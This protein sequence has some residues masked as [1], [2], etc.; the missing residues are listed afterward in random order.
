VESTPYT[1]NDH[2]LR[3]SKE[4]YLAEYKAARPAK[5]LDE[6]YLKEAL[7][8]LRAA[9]S[10]IKSIKDFMKH[11]EDP[12]ERELRVAAE[13]RAY[14]Q[15]SYKAA[16]TPSDIISEFL[17]TASTSGSLT[18]SHASSIPTFCQDFTSDLEQL[19]NANSKLAPKTA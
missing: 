5:D 9:G 4:K 17:T 18:S 13:V 7:S 16:F 3:S 1:Q 15:V 14:F 12:Y 11:E 19:L 2:Y 10:S 8:M 6:S